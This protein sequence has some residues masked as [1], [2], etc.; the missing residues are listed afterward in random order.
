M[1]LVGLGS[2]KLSPSAKFAAFCSACM[3]A[4][5]LNIPSGYQPEIALLGMTEP[6]QLNDNGNDYPYQ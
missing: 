2:W 4:T 5:S 6:F 1:Q 3:A